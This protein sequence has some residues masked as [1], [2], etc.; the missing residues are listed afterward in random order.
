MVLVGAPRTTAAA[1]AFT[2]GPRA[3]AGAA[4]FHEERL[5]EMAQAAEAALEALGALAERGCPPGQAGWAQ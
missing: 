1:S 3:W 2:S 4:S 5:L